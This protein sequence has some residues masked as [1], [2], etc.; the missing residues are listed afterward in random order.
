MSDA[1]VWLN[2]RL[3]AE[4]DASISILDRGFTLADGVFETMRVKDGQPVWLDDHLARLREGALVLGIPL[5]F[6]EAAIGQGLAHLIIAQG[7]VEASLRL[8]LTRGPSRTR[9]LWP[10]AQ[11]MTPTLLATLSPLATITRPPLTLVIAKSVRRNEHSPLSRIKSLNYGDSIIARREAEARG[12]GDCLLM[13]GAG[14]VAC[15]SVGNVFVR[16][17]GEW[18][19]P[20][21]TDGILAGIARR[22]LIP[23]LGVC[24]TPI[25]VRDLAHVE[26]MF[27][28]NSLGLSVVG[29]V[30][31]QTLDDISDWLTGSVFKN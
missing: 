4:R 3:V 20:P 28:A 8:T 1:M 30:E 24:E 11:P 18:H 16:M 15:S 7:A 5:P 10:P 12:A 21:I 19:T 14:R 6:D 26:A 23:V 2:G 29:A 27:L 9:G 31:G 22:H 13:N 17:R 25:E